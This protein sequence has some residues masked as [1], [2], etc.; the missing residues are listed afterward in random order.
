VHDDGDLDP[1]DGP[2][3]R[4]HPRHVRLHRRLAD[5]RDAAT[6]EWS[7][8]TVLV[9]FTQ[10]PRRARVV[11]AKLAVSVLLGAA[12]ALFG[13]LVAVAALAV[14]AASGRAVDVDTSA[15]LLGGFVLFVLL[16][17]LS[18]VAIGALLQHSAA[19]VVAYFVLPTG[20][21]V[22]GT[23]VAFVKEWIDATCAFDV[24]TS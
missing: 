22:L 3:F 10:E 20:F 2:E 9:T 4:E 5:E 16:N 12:G 17:V 7:Q 6:S 24:R 23:G 18:G 14:S 21:A 15:G 8:R 19:A 13:L 11:L 1:V